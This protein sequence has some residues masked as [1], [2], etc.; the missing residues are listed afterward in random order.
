VSTVP[1]AFDTTKVS[2]RYIVIGKSAINATRTDIRMSA[3]KESTM[4]RFDP[5]LVMEIRG[6]RRHLVR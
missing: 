5:T 6:W 4:M 1:L 2:L 3:T